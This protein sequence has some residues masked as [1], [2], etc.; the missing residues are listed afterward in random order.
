MSGEVGDSHSDRDGRVEGFFEQ[1][2]FKEKEGMRRRNLD[3][4]A[5]KLEERREKMRRSWRRRDRSSPSPSSSDS[6][7]SGMQ[8]R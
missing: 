4:A 6:S 2:E 7:S 8:G 5:G 1:K 3:T